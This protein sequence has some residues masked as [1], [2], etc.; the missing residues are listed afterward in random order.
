MNFEELK[1]HIQKRDELQEKAGFYEFQEKTIPLDVTDCKSALQS[2]NIL[3]E[4]ITKRGTSFSE[5][6]IK[7]D[8]PFLKI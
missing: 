3:C 5:K 2:A 4:E 6:L 7:G 8:T 1:E